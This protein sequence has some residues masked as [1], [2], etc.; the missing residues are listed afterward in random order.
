MDK[1]KLQLAITDE[2]GK[3]LAIVRD[4]IVNFYRSSRYRWQDE[5]VADDIADEVRTLR[6]NAGLPI[7]ER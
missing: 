4:D 3:V 7:Y 6:E 2:N 1:L 5:F